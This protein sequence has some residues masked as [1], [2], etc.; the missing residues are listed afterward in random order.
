MKGF[1][2]IRRGVN[3]CGIESSVMF[4]NP[5]TLGGKP[6]P[7]IPLPPLGPTPAAA[8]AAA[9][10]AAFLRPPSKNDD[11]GGA[12]PPA[13]PLHANVSCVAQKDVDHRYN[14]VRQLAVKPGDTAA[15]CAAC[16]KEPRCGLWAVGHPSTKCWLK[17]SYGKPG[18]HSRGRHFH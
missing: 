13:N 4:A 15:C 14:D 9:A 16:R 1:F 7:K 3:E 17:E 18:M 2:N 12:P 10:A 6:V 5:A 11:D 8:A